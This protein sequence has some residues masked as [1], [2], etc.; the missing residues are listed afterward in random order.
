MSASAK[1][2]TRA[3]AVTGTSVGRLRYN[4]YKEAYARI[5]EASKK[6]FYLEAIAIIE[7]LIADRLESRLTFLKKGDLSFKALGPLIAEIGRRETD[8][9]LKQLVLH[10][11]DMWRESRNNA[12]HEM[13]KIADGEFPTWEGRV[14][15]MGLVASK[16]LACL[17]AVDKRFKELRKLGE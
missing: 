5:T 13:V 1:K 7:S 16:G 3:R 17:R 12:M 15:A 10:D 14:R 8:E 9:K 2:R 6:G 4:L 11:V